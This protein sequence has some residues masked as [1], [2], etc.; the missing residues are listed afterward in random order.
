M[1]LFLQLSLLSFLSVHGGDTL[2]MV[3]WNMENFFDYH[4][5]GEGEADLEF[6]PY[7]SRR[8]TRRRFFA[9]CDAAAK[10]LLWIADRY[11][12]MPDV[13]GLAEIENSFVI[14]KFL[15]MTPLRKYGYGIVH[16][17]SPDRRGIDVALLYRKSAFR[18]IGT[19]LK[20]PE[21][22]GKR[23]DT[24][25]ILHARLKACD[26]RIADVLVNHHPSKFGGGAVS[27]G[28]RHSAMS[29]MVSMCD[30]L[31]SGSDFIVAMGDF[32][33]TPDGEQFSLAVGL[34]C[35]KAASLHESG[36]GTIRYEGKWD[37]IDMFMVSP[38][39]DGCSVMEICRIPFLMVRDRKHP[40]LKPFRT[41][42]GPRYSGGVSDHCPILLE[43]R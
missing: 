11:G 19:T 21:Y 37:L 38:D 28:K 27:M 13:I 9:K 23:M 3:F 40:G 20:V 1:L 2:R 25:H 4:D 42:T 16:Y 36:E 32:N 15:E 14:R 29:A 31:R 5:G 6:S 34:L 43:I 30:S 12:G 17:D 7:G 10:G 33:D 24:R 18:L 39:I 22:Q 8:W 26:G 35:N 41:Y